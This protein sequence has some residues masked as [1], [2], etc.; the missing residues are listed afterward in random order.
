MKKIFSLLLTGVFACSL[1]ADV[2]VT[3]KGVSNHVIVIPDSCP[4]H[5]QRSVV[6]MQ[7]ILQQITGVKLP[8]MKESAVKSGTPKISVGNTEFAKKHVRFAKGANAEEMAVKTF[9]N[10]III[11]GN[12]IVGTCFAIYDFLEKQCGCRWYDG[13]MKK[14]PKKAKLVIKDVNMQRSPSFMFRRVFTQARNWGGGKPDPFAN[15][16]C[17]ATYN[18]IPNPVMG[19]PADIHTWYLY[20]KDWPKEKL[21]LLSKNPSGRRNAQKGQLGPMTCAT[22]PEAVALFKKQLR[23]FIE[24]DR[25][26]SKK[27]GYTAPVL[28][29]ISIND[30]TNYFCY[31]DSCQAIVKKHGESGLLLHFI[32]MLAKDIAKD[33]PEVIIHTAA[34]SFTAPPPKTDIK[35]EPNVAVELS[36]NTG[37]YY[38]AVAEDT[39]GKFAEQ[40]KNW[41]SRT[42][43]LGIWDYWIFYWDAFPAPYHNV[44]QIKK[45][46]D[47]YYKNDVRTMRIESEAA[48]TSNF[49]ALKYWLA[50]QLMDDINQ[51][52]DALIDEFMND[53]YGPAAPEM[54]EFMKYVAERQQGHYNGVFGSKRF[55]PNSRPWLDKAFYD[56]VQPLFDRAEAKCKPGS[57]FLINVHRERIPVDVSMINLYDKIKPAISRKV[58]AERYRAYAHEHIKLRKKPSS[59]AAEM[60][61]INNE[62]EKYLR[63]AELDAM[64]KGPR[65][66]WTITKDW[67]RQVIKHYITGIPAKR[68]NDV[69]AKYENGILYL[70]MTEYINTKKIKSGKQTFMGDDWEVFLAGDRNGDYAQFLIAPNGK[71]DSIF[72]KNKR[73]EYR[74]FKDV[75]VKST[76][77]ADKWV[78]ELEIPLKS[79][80]FKEIKY[81]NFIRGVQGEGCAWSPTF[82]QSYGR[83][84]FF[85]SLT[86]K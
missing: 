39:K 47:F 86:F 70:R 19:R 27:Y 46:L 43:M 24:R 54:K 32:N 25:A 6:D 76:V 5:I 14:I 34:Y 51:D 60:L 7:N 12:S 42:K 30:C 31:C 84:A 75:K 16:R 48:D 83:P 56:K 78:V 74:K 35:A 21:H 59:H 53:F 41:G 57:M 37:N 44:H 40:I 67:S 55:D 66:A 52:A 26:D 73:L 1:W 79:L 50:Y 62:V 72:F 36:H 81:G 82:E 85:G 18:S 8:I 69:Q 2:T 22:H 9:G 28:Y 63:H 58:L 71:Y 29:N 68:K 20:T 15:L 33:Y 80:P 4:G 17:K 49:F 64:K 77:L 13:W 65:P 38:A 3:D 61:L 11:N 23:K 10:D 45:D